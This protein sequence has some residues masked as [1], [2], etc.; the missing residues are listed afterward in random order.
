MSM[1][2][3]KYDLEERLINFGVA[4]IQIS[5]NLPKSFAGNHLSCQLTRS[6]TAPALH[7]GE[8]LSEEP[9]NDFIHKMKVALKELRETNICLK[10]INKINW[11]TD[12]ILA[13]RLKECNELISI[14]VTSITTAQRN[15][16]AKYLLHYSKFPVQFS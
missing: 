16:Q 10:I 7:F 3:R 15:K 12:E 6:V 8:A 4:M 2:N 1:L 5:E 11:F 13:V 9:R 14:F